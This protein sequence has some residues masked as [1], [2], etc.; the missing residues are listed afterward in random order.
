MRVDAK[1][2]P[3]RRS[4]L[5]SMAQR[6]KPMQRRRS[7]G[8]PGAASWAPLAHRPKQPKL[9]GVLREQVK[10]TRVRLHFDACLH[11]A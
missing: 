2:L 11:P 5:G 4:F 6:S 9:P 8:T 10:F 7:A 1:P 3:N